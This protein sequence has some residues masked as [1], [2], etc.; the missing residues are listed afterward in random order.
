MLKKF[1]VRNFTNFAEEL[2][3][4][5]SNPKAYEYLKECISPEGIIRCAVVHGTNGVGKSNL[6]LAFFD[7]FEHLTDFTIFDGIY[8]TYLCENTDHTIDPY[9]VFEYTFFF[10]GLDVVYSYSKSSLKELVCEKLAIGGRDVLSFDRREGNT[11]F[12]CSLQGAETLNKTLSDPTL[13]A[14]KYVL[15]NSELA[16]NP[17]N[18]AFKAMFDFVGKMLYF[19]CLETRNYISEN[20]KHRSLFTEIIE[21]D[22]IKDFEEFLRSAG[23][24]SNLGV[25][26]EGSRKTIVNHF[27][28][29]TR[30]LDEVWSTGT[31]ALTLFYCW[32]LR[33]QSGGVSFLFIDEFDAFY[34]FRLSRRVIEILKDTPVQFVVTTHNPSNINNNILRPDCYFLM[35]T[36]GVVSLANRTSKELREAHNLEK[37]FKAKAF[38]A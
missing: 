29:G 24:E 18:R 2:V 25:E 16:D 11:T 9:A 33:M 37:M 27:A 3:F 21:A 19:K 22:K 5:F 38:D 30:A 31:V 1:K 7:I 20:P 17:E 28:H 4:D 32:L 35:D 15:K 23:I 14:L 13:S 36:A 26:G 8:R 10:E 34:H 6:G 12:T